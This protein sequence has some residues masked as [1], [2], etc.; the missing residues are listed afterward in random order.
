MTHIVAG[1]IGTRERAAALKEALIE[2][3]TAATDV[4]VFQVAD[5]GRHAEY[6]IG[7]DRATSPGAG[8]S[9]KGALKGAAAGAAVGAVAGAAAS[10]AAPLLAPAIIAGA[11]GAG[12]FAGSLAGAMSATKATPSRDTAEPGEPVTRRGGLMVAVNVGTPEQGVEAVE[13]LRAHGVEDIERADGQWRD[14]QWIDFD[15][16]RAPQR[17]DDAPAKAGGSAASSPSSSSGRR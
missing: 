14:G 13:C 8:A 9:G 12:A 17:V 1:R 10:T 11:T 3:G 5:A 4:A 6:P 7:G 15:P 16:L 2:R